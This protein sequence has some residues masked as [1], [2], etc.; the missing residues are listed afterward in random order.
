MG[1][2]ASG[3]S[4]LLHLGTVGV[5]GRAESFPMFGALGS[6]FGVMTVGISH[7]FRTVLCN[8]PVVDHI[9]GTWA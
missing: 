1:G 3:K 8:H 2:V 5:L 4:S 6:G 9:C 7:F